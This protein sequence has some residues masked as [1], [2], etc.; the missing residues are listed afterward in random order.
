MTLL[1]EPTPASDA[2]F[3]ERWTMCFRKWAYGSLADAKAKA[4]N[5]RKKHHDKTP[6]YAYQC[7][8]L[9]GSH[10]WH[11]THRAEFQGAE[12]VKCSP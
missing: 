9:R 11:L 12:N 8:L 7:P 3:D 1:Y 2:S 5:H 4:K 10:H 6:L